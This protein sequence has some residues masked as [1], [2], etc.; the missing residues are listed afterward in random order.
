MAGR[1]EET[2]TKAGTQ[3]IELISAHVKKL[4]PKLHT[5]F[6]IE[7]VNLSPVYIKLT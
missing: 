5:E 3:I 1:S 2:L 4:N 6:S 7:M